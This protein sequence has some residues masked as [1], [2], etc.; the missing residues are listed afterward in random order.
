MINL[1]EVKK[2]VLFVY[3]G[4]AAGAFASDMIGGIGVVVLG[5]G[6]AVG[7]A[8]LAVAGAVVGLAGYGVTRLFDRKGEADRQDSSAR[9]RTDR[10]GVN[11][12]DG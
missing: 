9:F 2:A 5:T 3:G 4:A 10:E 8:P 12:G 6:F 7:L 11:R 1:K